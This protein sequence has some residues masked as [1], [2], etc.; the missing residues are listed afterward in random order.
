[1]KKYGIE[2]YILIKI[3]SI[4]LKCTNYIICQ[5]LSNVNKSKLSLKIKR[6]DS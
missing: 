2:A 3:S 5:W 6:G 4:P 1:V